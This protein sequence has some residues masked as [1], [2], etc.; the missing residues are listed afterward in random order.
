MLS[1]ENYAWL[2][3]QIT[4]VH[5]YT[6]THTHT[7]DTFSSARPIS[8]SHSLWLT[9]KFNLSYSSMCLAVFPLKFSFVHART[10]IFSWKWIFHSHI[11]GTCTHTHTHPGSY[12]NIQLRLGRI[13]WKNFCYSLVTIRRISVW[14]M[15]FHS[16]RRRDRECESGAQKND[17]SFCVRPCVIFSQSS[18][19]HSFCRLP[20][21]G[22]LW[23]ARVHTHIPSQ[24]FIIAFENANYL[25]LNSYHLKRERE[26]ARA[27]SYKMLQWLKQASSSRLHVNVSEMIFIR[28]LLMPAR[29]RWARASSN[30]I[31]W[32]CWS[33]YLLLVWYDARA[34]M[35]ICAYVFAPKH[36]LIGDK[37]QMVWGF[38]GGSQFGQIAGRYS[39]NGSSNLLKIKRTHA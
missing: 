36:Y 38:C 20:L 3:S 5:T 7:P 34:F 12:Y 21:R 17:A 4:F 8:R 39:E 9:E 26:R 35:G 18:G 2:C 31:D 13:E 28:Q 6:H 11:R 32:E 33:T 23:M 29:W 16:T 14:I 19:W 15:Q 1:I 37:W 25:P 27:R 22:L 30:W 10:Y 24:L